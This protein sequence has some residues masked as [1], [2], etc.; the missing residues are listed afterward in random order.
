[1]EELEKVLADLNCDSSIEL[2]AVVT[3]EGILIDAFPKNVDM[4]AFG[5]MAA[6]MIGA[7]EAALSEL[8]KGLP[9]KLIV[10]TGRSKIIVI[11]SGPRAIVTAVIKPDARIE[12]HLDKIMQLTEKIKL[13]V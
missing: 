10:D 11:G 4:S 1:M 8:G 5:A 12:H 6:T 3:R 7:A 13:L 9:D 2:A